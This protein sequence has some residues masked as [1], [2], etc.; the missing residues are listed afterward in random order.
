M[1]CAGWYGHFGPE[2]IMIFKSS[3]PMSDKLDP[4]CINFTVEQ[5]SI[6][7]TI[8]LLVNKRCVI[9]EVIMD[10]IRHISELGGIEQNNFML[11][12]KQ[13]LFTELSRLSS[14]IK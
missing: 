3:Q 5:L 10:I 14:P 2:V 8:L 1:G 6:P 11:L 4:K 13:K 9:S 7:L 12:D